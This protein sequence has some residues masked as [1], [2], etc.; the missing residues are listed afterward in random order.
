MKKTTQK[1]FTKKLTQYSAL[2]A[3]IAGVANVNGQVDYTDLGLSQVDA[4]SYDLDVDNDGTAEF[5]FFN[6]SVSYLLI[7]P[8]FTNAG[9]MGLSNTPFSYPYFYPFAL[10]SGE[11][12]NSSQTTW[13]QGNG[14]Y[15]T[16]NW[17]N[18][19]VPYNQWCDPTTDKYLGL[20][21]DISGQTHYGW[22]RV[23]VYNLPGTGDFPNSGW[24]ITGYA[25][26]KTPD[27]SIKAGDEGVLGVDENNL[28]NS[29]KIVA[30]N[31]SIALFNLPDSTDFKLY[32]IIGQSV[33][34]GK[35]DQ[36]TYV[37]EAETI[38]S[39]IY[40]IEI[41]DNTTNEILKK[42]IVL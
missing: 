10:N 25:Y 22:A 31:K 38:A 41:R 9:I 27:T 28:S 7:A 11:D 23:S 12:I 21:F 29:V 42:K 1:P 32:S 26:E 33:L 16:M 37:I 15:Q 40:I 6:N 2:T 24:A 4:V 17:L 13:L 36:K 18:C 5:T 19:A 20:R 34:N 8:K 3:A 30:L 14:Y 35:T 39:G